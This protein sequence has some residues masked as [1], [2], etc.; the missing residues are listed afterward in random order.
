MEYFDVKCPVVV[1]QYCSRVKRERSY[2]Y[3]HALFIMFNVQVGGVNLIEQNN[4][5]E[6]FGH[7]VTRRRDAAC[8]LK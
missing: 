5:A 3:S 7:Q 2:V 4:S 8:K 1:L 6:K